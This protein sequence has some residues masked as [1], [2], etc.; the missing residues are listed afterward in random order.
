M[1]GELYYSIVV[2]N[3][4]PHLILM[5]CEVT[6][7]SFLPLWMFSRADTGVDTGPPIS[8]CGPVPRTKSFSLLTEVILLLRPPRPGRLS[9]VI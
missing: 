5:F 9:M 7:V 8:V 3:I 4:Y 2:E 1:L 6:T